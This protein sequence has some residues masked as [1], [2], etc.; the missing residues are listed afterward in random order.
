MKVERE[1][2]GRDTE[3]SHRRHHAELDRAGQYGKIKAVGDKTAWRQP[4]TSVSRRLR[5]WYASPADKWNEALPIGNGRLGG[6][7]FGKTSLE[8]VQLNEDSLWYGGPGRGA[9]PDATEYLSEIRG[10]LRDGRQAEAEHLARM[11]MTS[12][13][14]YE[15]PY[16]PLGDLLLKFLDAE[17]VEHY[18]R[19]LDLERSM[20]TV[21]YSSGGIGYRR[22]YFVS[23]P[24]GVM[25]I[26]LTADRPG[27]LTFAAN[28][29]RRPFDSGTESLGHDTLLMKGE[30]GVDGIS[31]CTA[32]RAVAGEGSVRTIG[33]FLSVEG[34]DSVTLLLS[35]QTSFRCQQ[36]GQVCLE[37]LDRTAGMSFEQLERR[38]LEEYREKFERF[39]LTLG[40]SKKDANRAG[41]TE[42]GNI[43]PNG[44]DRLFDSDQVETPN[45][46]EDD[47]SSLSTD[48]RLNLLKDRV[49]T[50]GASAENSD[51][52]LIALY[53]QYGRYLVISCSRPGSLAANLQGIWND[54]FTPPWES[55][56]TI[57]VN[58][59]MNYWPAELLSLAECH[60][61]LFDLIHRMLPNGQD[62]AR[63]M[64]G[65]RGFAAHHNT[66]LWGETRPEGILMTCTVWPMGAAWLCLHLW[67]HYRFGGDAD[68]LRERAYPVMKEAAV[69]LLDY[70]TVDE[71]GR[72][73]TGP[74]VSPENRF[75]LP[76]GAVGS[77]CMG[78][79]MDAQIATA[80]FRACLAAG[81]LVGDKDT[82][83]EELQT[84]LQEIPAPRIGRHGGIM[85]WLDDYEEADPGHRHISQLFALYPGEQIDPVQSPELAEAAYKTL[86]LRLAHGGGHTGWS[87]AWIINYYARLQHGAEAH[88][89]LVN[90]LASSTY[91][92]LLDCHPPFQIDGNFGGIAGVAEMLLQSHTGGLRLLPALPPQWNSGKVKGLRARGGF[93]VD[94]CWEEGELAQVKIRADRAG[95][96]RLWSRS[97]LVLI[98]EKRLGEVMLTSTTISGGAYC[99]SF[100]MQQGASCSWGRSV[101]ET[102]KAVE[103]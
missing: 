28:L 78:P 14:K 35:A 3:R 19:E 85:E 58:I 17:A 52:E 53:V 59:Q 47:L 63:E 100:L 77:L 75:V 11:A 48:Q 42:S 32:L 87:R 82:F 49:K 91:P 50:E 25:V 76:N 80:L 81:Q 95:E 7:V 10:M 21:S 101:E 43:I 73:I 30:C 40:S 51:P 41:L 13:P 27:A 1:I 93:V 15:Q 98:E 90:L 24:D 12:S 97:S 68:F 86:E 89:H 74:S 88:E 18:E 33:D 44:Q 67:E 31:F 70:M 72:R 26:R 54:S 65:C 71:E 16:Q 46:A 38:H 4:D 37:Q 94:M 39:S 84:A 9:N 61:P 56:Y 29:M 69:F 8:R 36:P 66:N 62:T 6:M 64:Y 2:T 5:L 57:N 34:A 92:N 79:A 96:C 45:R 22:Q 20:V 60:E 83:L 103:E 23:A 102:Y 55:K 99:Y